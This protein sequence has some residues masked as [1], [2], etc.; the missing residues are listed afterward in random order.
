MPAPHT[1]EATIYAVAHRAGVSTATVSRALA[2][3][4][5]VTDHTRSAVLEAA[6]ELRYVPKAAARALAGRRTNAIGLVLPHIDGPY[7]ADLLVGFEVAASEL[8]RSVVISLASPASDVSRSLYAL[9]GHVDGVGFLARSAAQDEQIAELSKQRPIV[10]VARRPI[11]GLPAFFAENRQEARKLTEHLLEQGRRRFVFV[12]RP[13]SGSDIGQRCR[14]YLDALAS[15]GIESL[16]AL[17]VDPTEAGGEAAAREL[18]LRHADADAVVCGNDQ[19]ALSV[20]KHLQ[21]SGVRVGE[22]VAVT[23][24]DD[25]LAARYVRPGLTS[26]RQ[27]VRELGALAAKALIALIDGEPVSIDHHTLPARIIHR[28]SCCQAAAPAPF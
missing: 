26:V 16:G 25:I 4:P 9:V 10:T 5:K 19:L 28:G 17:E 15:A 11:D 3:S 2:G 1:P 6:R 27:P 8:G 21:E 20:M 7:Y 24:W 13:E 22:D 23:G 14:G 18:R 12:G